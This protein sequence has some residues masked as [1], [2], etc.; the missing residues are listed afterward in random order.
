MVTG[1]LLVVTTI[2]D[3]FK[4]ADSPTFIAVELLLNITISVDFS[5][6]VRMAGFKKYLTKSHWNKLDFLIVFGCNIL[7]LI[8]MISANS[9][10][11]EEISEEMLLIF[12]SIAQ[13]LRMIVFAKKQR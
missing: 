9:D 5:F 11:S 1:T 7:F 13:S 6:R 12:W 8:T 4:V 3:G 2:V 10:L